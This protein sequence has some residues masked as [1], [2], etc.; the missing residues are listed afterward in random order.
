MDDDIVDGGPGTD[1][2]HE[3]VAGDATLTDSAMSGAGSDSIASIERATLNGSSATAFDASGF[4][5]NVTVVAAEGSI[6]LGGR[7]RRRVEGG[8][9]EDELRGGLGYD[10][11]NAGGGDDR[12]ISDGGAGGHRRAAPATTWRRGRARRRRGL[13]A[14]RSRR[15]T[16]AGGP[17][18]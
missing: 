10:V 1:T 11:F 4:G 18:R 6:L 16:V 17:G 15:R 14:D 13:R 12:T 8:E 3:I 7:R 9:G 5:G 2:V